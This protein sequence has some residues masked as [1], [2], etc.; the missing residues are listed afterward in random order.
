MDRPPKSLEK[1][2]EDT[3]RFDD[4]LT[5]LRSIVDRLEGGNLSLEDSLHSF[6][7]GMELCR[8]GGAILDAAEKKVEVLLAGPPGANRTAPLEAQEV[9]PAGAGTSA[10]GRESALAERG[11]DEGQAD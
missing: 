4:I 9:A 7:Q 11:A 10:R 2:V 8:R 5:R 1:P 3:E 6:E